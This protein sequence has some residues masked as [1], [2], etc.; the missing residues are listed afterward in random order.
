MNK[1]N[2]AANTSMESSTLK[3]FGYSVTTKGKY[4]YPA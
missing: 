4:Y 1:K 2:V 3:T